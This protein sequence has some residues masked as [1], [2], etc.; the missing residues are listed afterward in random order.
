MQGLFALLWLVLSLSLGYSWQRTVRQ[1]RRFVLRARRNCFSRE[2]WPRTTSSSQ[3]STG[4]SGL[5]ANFTTQTKPL[6]GELIEILE[7]MFAEDPLQLKGPSSMAALASTG[8][9]T[10]ALP[11]DENSPQNPDTTDLAEECFF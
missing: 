7:K 4:S 1:S 3:A 2:V 11:E 9:S 8:V 5:S 10:Q 6:F